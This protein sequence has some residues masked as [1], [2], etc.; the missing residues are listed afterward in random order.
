MGRF[1]PSALMMQWAL[2]CVYYSKTMKVNL[3][4]YQT[5]HT[6]NYFTLAQ[7]LMTRPKTMSDEFLDLT[8]GS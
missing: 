1:A 7:V 6:L 3:P 8:V 5:I 4:S 2:L